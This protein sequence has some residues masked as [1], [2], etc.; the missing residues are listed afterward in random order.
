MDRRAAVTGVL[1]VVA[2][3]LGGVTIIQA[4]AWSE[5]VD[6]EAVAEDL[7]AV[8][9]ADQERLDLR[10]AD[11][12]AALADEQ[13]RLNDLR[14]YFAPEALAAISQIQAMASA[15][16]C[17]QART[18]VRNGTSAPTADAVVADAIAA[19]P[20]GLDAL[21]GLSDRW[22]QMIEK[23]S[24]DAAIERC[25]AEEVAAIDAEGE[26][27]ALALFVSLARR[28]CDPASIPDPDTVQSVASIGGDE[29]MVVDANGTELIVNVGSGVV[30]PPGGPSAVIPM[31]YSFGCDP[32]VFQGAL[33]A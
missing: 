20:S 12:D 5:A 11:A 33:D 14:R 23:R 6:R 3:V 32:G 21:D 25:A 13:A 15:D 26:A 27:A 4:R 9:A 7:S 31:D 24:V 28:Y 17:E 2:V 18:A 22:G 16:G 29:Y 19:G 1:A 30:Y 8:L 10:A